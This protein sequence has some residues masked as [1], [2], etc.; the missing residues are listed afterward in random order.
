V[1]ECDPQRPIEI[2][3][4]ADNRVEAT[5]L[6][7]A[8]LQEFHFSYRLHLVPDEAAA[9]AFLYRLPPYTEV[10]WPHFLVVDLHF[11]HGEGWNVLAAARTLPSHTDIPVV[12]LTGS[13]AR[14]DEG[15]T[16][17]NKPTLC[18][19]KPLNLAE[20][21]SLSRQLQQLVTPGA[22]SLLTELH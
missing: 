21:Q 1:K 14:G 15:P 19:L 22:R 20:Y 10:P 13:R 6:Q 11:P 5:L 18:L 2:L 3:L 9:I 17:Q 7:I 12:I 16:T 4:V 8:L